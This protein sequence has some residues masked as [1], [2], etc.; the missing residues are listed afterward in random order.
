MFS[1]EVARTGNIIRLL[2]DSE[3]FLNGRCIKDV[4][5]S[6]ICRENPPLEFDFSP[7]ASQNIFHKNFSLKVAMSRFLGLC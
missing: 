5:L 4:E 3:K 6:G 2:K 7:N 1:Y